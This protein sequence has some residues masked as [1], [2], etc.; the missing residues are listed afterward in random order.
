MPKAALDSVRNLSFSRTYRL[1][2]KAEFQSVFA[3]PQKASRG[4]LLA[5]YTPNSLPHARLG[6]IV[7]KRHFKRAVDRNLL[8]R[9]VK[10]SFRHY[11][12]K[13]PG[14]DIVFMF[15]ARY[16]VIDKS[17]IRKEIDSLWPSLVASSKPV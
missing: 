6:V 5:L 1:A 14:L 10:E 3:N 8:R 17:N 9:L 2:S 13:L 11:C 12:D 16:Q 4:P 15:R 7:A